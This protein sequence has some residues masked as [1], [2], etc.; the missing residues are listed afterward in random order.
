MVETVKINK[1]IKSLTLG[2]LL[3][4]LW[5][6]IFFYRYPVYKSKPGSEKTS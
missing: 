2:I 3:D 6:Y 1:K 5:K 4:Q